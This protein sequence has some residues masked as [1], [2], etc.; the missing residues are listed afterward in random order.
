MGSASHCDFRCVCQLHRW[1][2][3]N[4]LVWII[5]KL[6]N[7]KKKWQ[8]YINHSFLSQSFKL[9][10][11]IYR[12]LLYCLGLFWLYFV[13]AANVWVNTYYLLMFINMIYTCWLFMSLQLTPNISLFFYD[14]FPVPL[15]GD[16][17]FLI[18][19]FVRRCECNCTPLP[20][21]VCEDL[22]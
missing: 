13:L 7:R 9:K 15:F 8:H 21:L 14:D 12:P 4:P 3:V 22:F 5:Y 6:W 17:G 19:A 11:R 1:N 16:T 20:H 10:Y 18:P 2:V